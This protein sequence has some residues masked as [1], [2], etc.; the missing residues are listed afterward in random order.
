MCIGTH[1]PYTSKAVRQQLG[2]TSSKLTQTQCVF[3]S[4]LYFIVIH[5]DLA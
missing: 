1:D 3:Y 5:I 2:Y 4:Y